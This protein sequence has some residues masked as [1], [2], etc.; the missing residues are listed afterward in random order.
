MKTAFEVFQ[1]YED[2]RSRLPLAPACAQSKTIASLME[3]VPEIDAFV[4]DAFGVLNVGEKLIPG[5]DRRLQELR[6]AGCAIR[7]L[8]NAASYDKSGAIE[9]F[10]RLGIALEDDEIITSRD[11][12]LRD[13][14]DRRWGAIAAPEDR[15]TDLPTGTIR[16]GDDPDT[17]DAVDG[18][19]FLSTA[20]WSE[21]RQSLLEASLAR[22]ARPLV[23]A[24]ADLVAPREDGFSLEPGFY[25]HRIAD[26]TDADVRFFGKPYADVF[27]MAKSTLPDLANNRIAMCGDSLHTDILG[28]AAYGW[29]SVLVTR[30]GL[31]AG[32]DVAGFTKASGIHADWQLDRI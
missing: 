12:A 24:N 19:L 22:S 21:H 25:G 3:L 6:K 26:I 13:L 4:F 10:Q 9:K 17:Y 20:E 23:I 11:A 2:I 32:H 18:I 15:L 7:V 27:A 30:D 16:L 8:T 31:F 14:D 29:R 5:A 28:A 1:R